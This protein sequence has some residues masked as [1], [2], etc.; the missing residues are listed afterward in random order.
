MSASI[1]DLRLTFATLTTLAVVVLMMVVGATFYAE[2][3]ANKPAAGSTVL[4]NSGYAFYS[5]G[6]YYLSIF[7]SDGRGNPLAGVGQTATFM[8]GK[9]TYPSVNSTTSQDG[10]CQLVF[11]LPDGN[12]TVSY[13]SSYPNSGITATGSLGWLAPGEVVSLTG[14][15]SPI[16]PVGP[17]PSSGP[18]KLIVF[19]VGPN[20]S[21]PSGFGV[22][23][24]VLVNG[25]DTT[26]LPPSQ[27]TAIGTLSTYDQALSLQLPPAASEKDSVLVEVFNTT[28]GLLAS[29]SFPISEL[30]L[31][32]QPPPPLPSGFQAFDFAEGG[33]G[34]VV[35]I[36]AVFV[37]FRAYGQDRSNGVLE[38]LLSSPLSR[39]NVALS[40]YTAGAA[41]LAIAIVAA[42]AVMDAAAWR[43]GFAV[44]SGPLYVLIVASLLVPGLAMLGII[45]VCSRLTTSSTVMFATGIVLWVIVSVLWQPLV[46]DPA[47]STGFSSSIS[48]EMFPQL[49]PGYVHLEFANPVDFASLL[50]ALALPVFQQAGLT[51]ASAGITPLT[52]TLAALSWV[53]APFLV[54]WELA[55]RSD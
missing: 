5:G 54:F 14:L 53:V 44:F 36:V 32:G 43:T 42:V 8:S 33:M 1:Y 10:R 6:N 12:Y 34:L 30:S 35:P 47:L 28:A 40:R 7:T 46:L 26:Y 31:V 50:Q 37:A 25:S 45:L 2:L 13:D 9:L 29:T 52:V 55:R 18:D 11:R 19:A 21:L 51:P 27:M 16:Y 48:A 38:F 20:D 15:G 4:K 39:S 49:Q 3:A 41:T 17:N 24:A 22:Y 23:F